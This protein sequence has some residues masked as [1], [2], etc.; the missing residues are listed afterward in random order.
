[1]EKNILKILQKKNKRQ[2]KV[3]IN[4]VLKLLCIFTFLYHFYIGYVGA[5]FSLVHRPMHLMLI[6]VIAFFNLSKKN[7]KYLN[8]IPFYEYVFIILTI[9]SCSYLIFNSFEIGMRQPF[10]VEISSLEFVLGI[11][12]ILMI[13]I[14]TYRTMGVS[15]V[16]LNIIFILYGYFGRYLPPPLWHKGY[17]FKRI[18]EQ[19]YSTLD[20]IWGL[21]IHVT[22]TYGYLFIFFGTF[23]MITGTGDFFSDFAR[24]LIGKRNIVGAAPKISIVSSSLMGTISG[25]STANVVT[26][27]AFTIPMMKAAGYPTVF[28]AA[29]EAVASTGGQMVPPVMGAAAFILAEFTGIPYLKVCMHALI[30]AFLYYLSLYL[31]VHLASLKYGDKIIKETREAPNLKFVLLSGGYL[32]FPIIGLVVLLIMGYTPMRAAFYANLILL[33]VV[34]LFNKDRKRILKLVL[35]TIE[36]APRVISSVTIACAAAGIIIG[37]ISMTGLGQRLSSIVLMVSHGNLLITLILTMFITFILGMGMP[38]SGAYIITAALMPPAMM[39]LG[40]PLIAAHMF[41]FYFASVSSITPPVALASY[42][43]AG[44]SGASPSSVGWMAFRIGIAAYIVPYMMV[45]APSLLLIGG[46]SNII[47][48]LVTSTIGIVFFAIGV[49][50]FLF[51][52]IS[53]IERIL[54]ATGGFCLIKPGLFI[55]TIGIIIVTSLL[56]I[57]KVKIKNKIK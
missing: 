16:I 47:L 10:F 25:S 44:I 34:F 50:G 23:L 48:V 5:P 33:F 4:I 42:A 24:S 56:I 7:K 17:S 28:A 39:K 14:A 9:L 8:E 38:T 32:I 51:T 20:G 35:P 41:I 15:L 37:M 29:V 19:L 26:T 27:G 12:L 46:I 40:V 31:M 6:L 11:I 55:N 52:K 45:Y 3:P 57:Q 2:L 1:M 53:L 13:G 22:A 21:P 43:A 18:V 54:F 36:K 30:P 49:Q